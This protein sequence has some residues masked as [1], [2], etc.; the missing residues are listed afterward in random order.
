MLA[1]RDY[2]QS[3]KNK[4]QNEIPKMN[5]T[6]LGTKLIKPTTLS[7]IPKSIVPQDVSKT[8][9]PSFVP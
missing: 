2:I 8:W 1:D 6:G 9:T 4:D 3:M 7:E 5:L